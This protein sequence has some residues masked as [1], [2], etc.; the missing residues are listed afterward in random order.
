MKLS[1]AKIDFIQKHL[2]QWYKEHHR[3]LP[4]RET[5]DP[6]K[7]W[8]SEVML[9]QTQ[10][11]TVIP[12][13]EKFISEFPTIEELAKSNLQKVLKIWEGLGYYARAR[14]LFKAAQIIINELE[15]NIPDD[16]KRFKKLP[17]VGEYIASAVQSIAFEQ[18][19][20]AVDGNVKRVFARLFLMEVPVNKSDSYIQFKDIAT[21]LLDKNNAGVFNQ[22]VMELG[23]MICTP[24]NPNC[25]E[26][27]IKKYC[28]ALK[29]AN[30]NE[31]PKRI[32]RKPVPVV[33][34][35]TGIVWNKNKLLIARR[36]SEGLLGGLWEFPGGDIKNSDSAE[37]ACVRTIKD[38]T[39]IVSEI[40]NYLTKV[41]HAYTHFKIEMEVFCCRYISG[42]IRLNGYDDYRWIKLDDV[43]NYA[44]P[45]ANLKFVHLLKD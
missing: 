3:Q 25:E 30:V 4:W 1:N 13:F 10:V 31:Y 32:Q 16:R 18:P 37:E 44:F 43:G 35:V 17:G 28:Q 23:A 8:V 34:K 7:I 22:A 12:Y 39:G 33:H 36:K 2:L 15:G 24:I 20:A 40:E 41:K 42:E 38:K 26:C 45:K 29:S 14:N 21:K 6:Y 11:K 27:P 9:Q 19:H 5:N